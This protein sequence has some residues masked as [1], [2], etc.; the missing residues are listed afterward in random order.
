MNSAI[1]D[2]NFGAWV[3]KCNPATWD[4]GAFIDDG[5]RLIETWSVQD[6]YRSAR[7]RIGDPVVFWVT[8]ADEATPTP[9]IWG[10]GVVAA[11][12][13]VEAEVDGVHDPG[14]WLDSDAQLR[15]RFF[16]TLDLPLLDQPIPRSTIKQLPALASAELLRQPQMSNPS[17]LTLDEWDALRGLLDPDLVF[18]PAPEVVAEWEADAEVQQPDALTRALVEVRAIAFVRDDLTAAGW[19]V[20]DVQTENCGWDLTARRDDQVRR[21]EVKGRGTR[22][23]TCLL[24][25]NEHRAAREQ[26]GWELAM[27]TSALTDPHLVYHRGSVVVDTATVVTYKVALP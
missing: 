9:G 25:A 24:T 18:A 17:W 20:E 15:A 7:M 12:V 10:V 14:Y 26:D 8:G 23:T 22:G 2:S 19:T 16:A 5:G 4:L 21:I 1:T 11:P 13:E 3:L 6:N 27:V